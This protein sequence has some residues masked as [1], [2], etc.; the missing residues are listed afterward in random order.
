M[1]TEWQG[2]R[3]A[4]GKAIIIAIFILLV[5]GRIPAILTVGRFWAEEGVVYYSAAW[6]EPW[7]DALFTVHTGYI[8][9][10]ASAATLL[11]LHLTSPEHAPQVTALFACAVQTLPAIILATSRIPWLEN[12]LVF[13][14]ALILLLIPVGDAEVWLNSITSQFHM[15]LCVGL[16]L[17]ADIRC[18]KV[19]LLRNAILVLAPLTGP[20]SGTLVPVFLL[21][22]GLER[23]RPRLIQTVCLGIPTLVQAVMILTHPEPARSIGIGAPL[24]LAVIGIQNVILPIRGPSWATHLGEGAFY[25]FQR[26]GLSI[27]AILAAI[28]GIGALAFVLYRRRDRPAQW[29]FVAGCTLAVVGYSSALTLGHPLYLLFWIGTRYS[30]APSVLL[31]LSLLGLAASGT[32]FQRIISSVLVIWMIMIGWKPYFEVNST[33]TGGTSWPA[34][35]A[36]WRQDPVYGMQMWPPKW[37]VKLTLDPSDRPGY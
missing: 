19:G 32:R 30:Y 17:A 12:K 27:S 34:E 35:V 10:A 33:F 13:A 24:L 6:H 4:W 22:A 8:N 18:G 31:S 11:A 2:Y 21:R 1:Q 25:A 37:P 14:A 7:F 5:A 29:L 20:L 26:G 15:A 3:S 16:I 36:K 23:S 28:F 9:I